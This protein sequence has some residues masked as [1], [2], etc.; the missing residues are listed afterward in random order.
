MANSLSW[1]FICSHPIVIIH[2][3]FTVKAVPDDQLVSAAPQVQC[4]HK[5]LA[6]MKLAR[7]FCAD[8]AILR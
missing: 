8:T 1:H 6:G 2:S 7:Y 4:V 3:I 5:N